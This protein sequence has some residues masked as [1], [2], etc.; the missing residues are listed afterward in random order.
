[1]ISTNTLSVFILHHDQNRICNKNICLVQYIM[2]TSERAF[3]KY[4][5]VCNNFPNLD[6]LTKSATPGEVQ[7][8]FSHASVG[9]IYLRESVAAFALAGSLDSPSVISIDINITFATDGDKIRLTITEVL[10]RAAAGNLAW[11]NKQRE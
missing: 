2:R 1:M 4:K 7:M 11:S 8:M 3:E 10:I 9:N 5:K 6:I